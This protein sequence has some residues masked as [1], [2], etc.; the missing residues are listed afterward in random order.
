MPEKQPKP[1]LKIDWCSY[2]AAK[3]AVE[4]W[5]YSRSI[6][7]GKLAKF[8]VWEDDA[9][10]GAVIFGRGATRQLV[11]PYGLNMNE[12]CELVRVALTNHVAQVSQIVSISLRLLARSM[13]KLRLVVSYA[14]PD[15]GHYGGIYQA[16]NWVY[17]GDSS[18]ADEYIVN[19][20]R[21]HGRSLRSGK[22]SYMTTKQYAASLDPAFRLVMGSSKHRYLYPLDAEMRKQIEPLRQPYPKR[23]PVSG[24]LANEGRRCEPDPDAPDNPR[25]S[26]DI[27]D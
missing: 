17:T 11:M 23:P 16:G 2:E 3:Y 22:P 1:D 14:D 13:P 4:H 24:T 25:A 9:F 6:P 26:D 27:G 21:W 8:G 15:H 12:G 18:S 20:K 7:C 5:H 10:K 19:G